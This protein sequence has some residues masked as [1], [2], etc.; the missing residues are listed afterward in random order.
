MSSDLRCNRA[1]L[2]LLGFAAFGTLA[3]FLVIG[4]EPGRAQDKKSPAKWTVIKVEFKGPATIA[5]PIKKGQPQS[6]IQFEFGEKGGK[7]VAP[8]MEKETPYI[9]ISHVPGYTPP[10]DDFKIVD[11]LDKKLAGPSQYVVGRNNQDT[12]V[13][14]RE[15]WKQ[16]G[17]LYLAGPGD[18]KIALTKFLPLEDQAARKLTTAKLFA[19]NMQADQAKELCQQILKQYGKTKSAKE[20]RQLLESLKK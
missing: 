12:L 15:S 5:D 3:L 8:G 13:F 10:A 6:K 14:K 9:T 16:F 2:R 20:A 4:A 19:E 1:L 18:Q 17:E 11:F 7:V